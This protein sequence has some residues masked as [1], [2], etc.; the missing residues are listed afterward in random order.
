MSSHKHIKVESHTHERFKALAGADG[1][2]FDPFLK[3]LLDL[4][5]AQQK[6]K[7]LRQEG[8]M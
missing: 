1:R 7:Q 6:I 5:E 3:S 4:Y 8:M 2:K